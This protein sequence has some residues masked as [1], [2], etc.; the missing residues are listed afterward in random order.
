LNGRH[1]LGNRDDQP[2]SLPSTVITL[3]ARL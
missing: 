1:S 3:T 2:C